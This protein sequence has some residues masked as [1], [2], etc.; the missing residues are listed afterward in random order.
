MKLAISFLC[1]LTYAHAQLTG[2]TRRLDDGA[3]EI[4]IKKA[5]GLKIKNTSTQAVAAFAITAKPIVPADG[6]TRRPPPT[7]LTYH[8]PAIDSTTQLAAGEERV[9][10]PVEIFCEPIVNRSQAEILKDIQR[11]GTEKQ[12]RRQLLCQLDQPVIAAV[13]ADGSTTGDPVLL[14]RLELR[15]SNM[16]LAIDT[17]TETL[18]RAGRRNVPREQ[19]I[20]EFK[21]LADAL[22]R[23]YLPA[24]QRIGSRI[25][26]SVVA[27]LM[28]LPPPDVG[29]AFPPTDFVRQET[30]ELARQ[31]LVIM[32]SQPSLEQPQSRG[33][34]ATR[35][36]M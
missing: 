7:F 16:L 26:Q 31:R 15:R 12:Y 9:L 19:L 10:P 34:A 29:Q 2:E 20:A 30:A 11:T 18:S 23:W 8:D 25:Y 21:N 33:T 28:K 1:V 27:K 3:N 13:F 14:E 6:Q 36:P 17:T 22:N 35:K 5:N 4:K 24:E 32:Q